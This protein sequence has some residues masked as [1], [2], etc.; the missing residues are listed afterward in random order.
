MKSLGCFKTHNLHHKSDGFSSNHQHP[1][2][3]VISI[4][5]VIRGSL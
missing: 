4:I 1:K 5:L 3:D 2:L